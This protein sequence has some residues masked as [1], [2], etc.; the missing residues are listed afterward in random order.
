M[1]SYFVELPELPD[2]EQERLSELKDR[3]KYKITELHVKIGDK[4]EYNQA[5]IE[6]G[7]YFIRTEKE[8]RVWT[9]KLKSIKDGKIKRLSINR[10]SKV[11]PGY[12][13]SI[14]SRTNILALKNKLIF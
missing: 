11:K 3:L 10:G 5:L 7:V 1:K 12:D 6:Y 14:I 2:E 4:V 9:Q 8:V 13:L